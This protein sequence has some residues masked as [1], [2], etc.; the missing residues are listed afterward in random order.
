MLQ[1]TKL[2]HR[3]L[4]HP[5]TLTLKEQKDKLKKKSHLPLHQKE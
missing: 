3:N 2:I 4:L 1:D 5:Y